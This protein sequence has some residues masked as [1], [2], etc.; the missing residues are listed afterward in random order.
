MKQLS[1]LVKQ[2]S[3]IAK[4]KIG[5]Y[6]FAIEIAEDIARNC[7][8]AQ[9]ESDMQPDIAIKSWLQDLSK[10]GVASGMAGKFIY[11]SDCAE[12]YQKNVLDLDEWLQN[13]EEESG[14]IK[15]NQDRYI[16]MCWLAYEECANAILEEIEEEWEEELK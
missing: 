2:F 3:S 11:D 7:Y 13:L 12:F 1:D 6:S 16:S 5:D 8:E 4:Q 10:H 14:G 15:F 9:C